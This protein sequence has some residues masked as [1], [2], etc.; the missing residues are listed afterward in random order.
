MTELAPT[1]AAAAPSAG[2]EPRLARAGPALAAAATFAL[3]AACG[4]RYG[5]FRDELYFI[6]CGERLA[7][8]Y[9]DQ[10]PGIALVA[11]LASALFGTWVPGLRLAAWLAAAAAV[12]LTGR[13]GARLSSRPASG[14]A[15]TLAAT[16]AFACLVL[17]GTGHLLTM[18]AFEPL[19]VL[20][21]ALVLLR[22]A[23][24]GHPRLWV[25]AGG[26]AGLAVIFKYSAAA[27][28]LALL[29]GFAAAPSRRA[30]RTRWALAGAAIGALVVL[31]NLAWQASHG[32]PFAEL[33]RNGVLHKNAP[34]TPLR[35]AGGVL[36]E[37]NPAT[38]PLWLGG[39]AWLLASNAARPARF[40]GLG[41]GVQLFTLA[42]GRGKA[43]YA[44]PLLPVLLAG[45]GAAFAALVSSRGA[46]R[47]VGAALAASGLALSPLAVPILPEPTFVAY[48][49]A[50][51]VRPP[52][53][54]RRVQGE[55]PQVFADMHGWR[56]LVAA[57][58]RVYA[59]LPPE[60]RARAAVFGK[61]YGV[62]S[63]V[64]VLGP[65]AGLPR[66]L[67]ISGHNQF[68]FWGVPPGRGDPLVLVGDGDEDC[69]GLF[70]QRVLAEQLPPTPWVMPD[71]DAHAIWI[72]RG[73]AA[74][75]VAMPED[76]RHFE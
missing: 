63:A 57:V 66:G 16:A 8:G 21:L 49:R 53:M 68:W 64:E 27:T 60:E 41:L 59:A 50:L 10:P 65:A 36:L 12:Y 39:L 25:A 26:I 29:V 11:R 28:S 22:L 35:F 13:L 38:A 46:A 67:A 69:G 19:L 47:G 23:E 24:G 32:F 3:H 45:G 51:G 54:E 14:T 76:A 56:E 20:A 43:Y 31:P 48:Q 73:A 40:L 55:L 71:E 75:L 58:A 4:G 5:L 2:V 72:C 70:R 15:A 74:P 52:P 6:V 61:N 62:A 9:V 34:M 1:R 33:V 7:A 37:A 30:L 42:F 17:R 44:A 18:N